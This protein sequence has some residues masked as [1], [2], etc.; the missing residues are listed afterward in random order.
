MITKRIIIY[1]VGA[2]GDV[3]H[4]LPF[5]KLLRKN[6]PQARIE[7]IVGSSQLLDLLEQCTDYIDKVWLASKKTLAQDMSSVAAAGKVDEFIFLHSGWLKACWLNYRYIKSVKLCVYKRDDSLSA[8]ANY[9]TSYYP[10]LR[11]EL[12]ADPF[13]VLE[14]KTLTPISNKSVPVAGPYICIVPGVG[15]LRPHRAYPL[16]KWADLIVKHLTNS[17]NNIAL[18]GGPDELDIG[19]T[20]DK[21]VKSQGRVSNFIAKTSLVELVSILSQAQQLY[22]ADTGILHVGAALGVP[23]K[24]VF[25]ITSSKRFGP[26]SPKAETI[27]APE[28]LCEPSSTN[29]PKHCQYSQNNIAKCMNNVILY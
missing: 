18:L 5:V 9:V 11:Q 22:S 27:I 29:R 7:Y 12:L 13:S 23:I 3:V 2:I 14:W 20:L 24:A 6:N 19:L 1:R 21:M 26:F 16:D 10:G 8:V 28:C 4:T 15:N 17:D 25:S